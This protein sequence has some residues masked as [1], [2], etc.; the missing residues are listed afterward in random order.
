M[1]SKHEPIIRHTPIR[2][3]Y[4]EQ[5]Q[6]PGDIIMLTAAVRD[7]KAAYPALRIGVETTAMDI[8]LNNPRIDPTLRRDEADAVVYAEYPDINRSND[9]MYHFGH[10]FRHYLAGVL[11][12]NVPQTT[13]V[14]G[15]VWI[16]DEEAA[17]FAPWLKARGLPERGYWLVDAGVKSDYTAKGWELERWQAVVDATRDSIAW[18]QIGAA[19]HRHPALK[20]VVDLRGQTSTREL[21]LLMHRAGGV[22]TPVSF[23]MH[24]AAAVPM[25]GEPPARRRPC[26]VLAGGRE[27]PSWVAYNEHQYVHTCGALPCCDNGGCWRSRVVP[28]GDGDQKD[29]SLCLFRVKSSVSG[30]PIQLCM[31]MIYPEQIVLLVRQ[32]LRYGS[33]RRA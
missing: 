32:Y 26:I 11:G 27:P 21:I 30:R 9:G 3:L 8:W 10:A 18:A 7:I 24:L 23:P 17:R 31:E 22:I 29:Q 2:S 19:E 13:S 1:P 33:A 5:G 6:S 4:I 28:L 20:N 16:N 14:R 25:W 15:E 12:L